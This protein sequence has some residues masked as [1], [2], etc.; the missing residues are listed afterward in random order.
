MNESAAF[1]KASLLLPGCQL[2]PVTH[3]DIDIF[4]IVVPDYV[5]L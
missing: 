4:P 3:A 5:W 2:G 1:E